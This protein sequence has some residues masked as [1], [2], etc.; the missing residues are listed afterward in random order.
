MNPYRKPPEAFLSDYRTLIDFMSG[1]NLNGL[2]VWGLLRDAHG[3]LGS[4]QKLCRYAA[5]K[6]IRILAGVGVMAYGGVFYQGRSRYSME[7]WLRDH[8][9]LSALD[10]S[11]ESYGTQPY[12]GGPKMQALCPSREENVEWYIEG[13][14]WLLKNL[15]IGGINYESGDYGVCHCPSCSG[16]RAGIDVLS[17]GKRG[18][19]INVSFEAMGQVYPTLMDTVHEIR[20]DLWQVY[21]PYC[22]YR[23]ELERDLRVFLDPIPEYAIC[24]WTLTHMLDASQGFDWPE[25]LCFPAAR[26]IGYLHQGSQ[27]CDTL[28]DGR[29]QGRYDSIVGQIERAARLGYRSGLDGLAMHG[30]VSARHP[31]CRGNYLAFSRACRDPAGLG[32][33]EKAPEA[34]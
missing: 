2:V 10:E 1:H 14:E 12:P 3:G 27:W 30:E 16:K 26:N 28:W 29:P 15:E 31:A 23:P 25:G 19:G 9:E 17:P 4:A 34:T 11:G 33:G 8:P 32:K 18:G 5:G 6:G 20:P 21:S 22:G 7:D 24:Q 13:L